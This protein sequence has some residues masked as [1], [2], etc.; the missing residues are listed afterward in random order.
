MTLKQKIKQI[1]HIKNT[2]VLEIESFSDG[3]GENRHHF[4]FF[5][6]ALD[7]E[8]NVLYNSKL[9]NDVFILQLNTN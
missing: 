1:K 2:P 8:T 9:V 7:K 3:V 6:K 5:D 4:F